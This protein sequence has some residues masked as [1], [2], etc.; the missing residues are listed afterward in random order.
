MPEIIL[1]EESYKIIGICMNIHS[2]LGAG[3]KEII[4]KD[5]LEFV[6]RKNNIHF[7]R[8]RK[9]TVEYKGNILPHY[10]IADFIVYDAI[11]LEVKASSMIPGKFVQQTLNYLKVSNLRLGILANF[12]QRSFSSQRIVL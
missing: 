6:F 5:V 7:S 8:E 10:F 12:G 9:F 11:I 4:Y 1:P 2:T 3:F